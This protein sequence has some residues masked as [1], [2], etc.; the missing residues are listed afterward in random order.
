VKVAYYSPLPPS[1]SGVA[2]YS[3]LLLP[4]LRAHFEEVVVASPGGRAP[5]ADVALYHVG[6]DPDAH[7]WIVDA[8]RKRPGVVV[9]HEYVLH[10]LIAG[11]TIG[12]GD[13]RAYLDAMERELGVAGR[14]LGLGVLDNLLPLLWETQP[15]RFPL[16]GT[17]LDL[18][19]GLIVHSRFV[20][21]RAR[22]A[23]YDGPVWRVAHPAWPMRDVV[24]V[25]GVAGDPLIGCFGYL[26]MNKRI[27]QLLEAFA[28]FRR[29][30]PG[31]RLLLVGAAAE[32]F[33][34][35]RRLER[36]GLADGVLREDYVAEERMWSLM[37]ACDVLVNLRYPT[38]GETSGSVIRGLSLGK[39]M[40]VSDVGWFAELPDDVALK[41][42]VDEYEV[43][44]LAA[45]LEL[46]TQCHEQL[47]A[48]ALEY[49]RE[50]HDLDGAAAGYARA[51]E[52][53]AGGERV[54]D[55]FLGELARAA[56]EV[57]IDDVGELAHRVREAGLVR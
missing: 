50:E 12:R 44:T 5:H 17:I 38:M 29:S 1:R 57:G 7:G 22:E 24:P 14:L 16:T 39:A 34:L 32:R 55:A 6:N 33:D 3:T 31:A 27:P 10:H 2:D 15:E 25:P 54:A 19:Q 48:R 40:F 37:A 4:A 28:A 41:I 20:E 18:A 30:H 46:V 47:G 42:P 35:G 23:G 26:N 52:E 21:E 13:G 9:L 36:L 51:I 53:A 8:L 45:A 49:V 43:P 11:I 56:A